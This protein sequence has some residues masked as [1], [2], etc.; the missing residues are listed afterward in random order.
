MG[1]HMKSV[2][3]AIALSSLCL[4][5]V[6]VEATYTVD[7]FLSDT[8]S[9]AEVKCRGRGELERKFKLQ[10][11]VAE[12]RSVKLA[13]TMICDCMPNQV[14]ELRALLSASALQ[15]QM[16][17][18]EFQKHYGPQIQNKCVAEQLRS[19]Y[20][21]GCGE[22]FSTRLRNSAAYCGCMYQSLSRLPDSDVA[23]IASESADYLPRAAEAQK[24]GAP[25]P[26]QPP[27]LK[28]FSAVDEACRAK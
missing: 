16:T 24:R 8:A 9:I 11:K 18:T 19:T 3:L 17:E 10:G 12:A 21:E 4:S 7:R 13:E 26:E 27:N 28:Q 23:L 22:A 15:Q 25:I 20:A 1:G 2:L 6:A 14:K 5:A